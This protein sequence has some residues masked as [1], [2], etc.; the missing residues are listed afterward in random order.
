MA[1]DEPIALKI[2]AGDLFGSL[3]M[4][5]HSEPLVVLIIAGSGPTDRDGNNTLFN[6]KNDSLK[7]LAEELA[8]IGVAS[9]R[10]DKRGIGASANAVCESEL[11]FENYVDDAISWV[12]KLAED[13]R[14]AGVVVLGHS[15]GSL[16]GMLAAANSPAI[17]YISI[18]GT[19]RQASQSLR[20]QLPRLRQ[21]GRK[22]GH[23]RYPSPSVYAGFQPN[24][25]KSV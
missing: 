10:Y 8:D 25:Q 16:I 20:E 23:F 3:R 21:F 2:Q 4:P 24:F 12:D 13:S 22:N 17:A 19:S 9:V 15:E 5:S 6:G 14:F 18:A 7:M 11:R 1:F